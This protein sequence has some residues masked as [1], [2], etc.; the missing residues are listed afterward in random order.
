MTK[1]KPLLVGTILLALVT[2]VVSLVPGFAQDVKS[3]APE[4]LLPAD[5]L[6]YVGW[7]GTA[8]HRAAWEKT[9]AYEAVVK[10][11]LGD[12]IAKLTEFAEQQAGPGAPVRQVV[13]GLESLLGSGFYLAVGAPN[14]GDGP[15]APQATLVVPGGAA[16]IVQINA[17]TG[18]VAAAGA[19]EI[20]NE[21]VGPRAVTRMRIREMPGME[22][23]WWAEGK[24]LVIAAGMGAV[25]TALNTA[26]GKSPTIETSAVWKKYRAKADFEVALT[27]WIDLAAI[28]KIAGPIPV[29]PPVAGQPPTTVADILKSIGLD[30]IGPAAMRLGFKGK[31]VWSETTLEAPAPRTGLLAWDSKP[32]ALVDLPPLPEATDGFYAGRMDWSSI[33]AGLVRTGSELFQMLEPPNAPSFGARLKDTERHLGVDLQK[34]LFDPLGDLIVFYGDPR[35]GVFGLGTGLAISVDDAKTLRA[36]LDKL[37]GPLL[38]GAGPDV[39]V[40]G[41]KKSGRTVRYL[42]FPAFPIISP[43]WTVDDKW[44]VIGLSPQTIDAFIR[45]LDGKLDRWVPNAE[46]KAALAEMPTKYTSITYSDPREGIRTA[47]SMVPVLAS[48]V[49]MMRMQSQ[50]FPGQPIQQQPE[51]PFSAA[52]LPPAEVVTR[53][54]FPN[55]SVCTTTDGEIRWTSRTSLPAVPLLGGAGLGN[56]GTTVPVLAALLLPAVQQA[57][58]AARRAQSTNNLKQIGLALHN[59]HDV[60]NGFPAGTH[61]NEKLKP[62]KRLSWQVDILPYIDQAPVYNQIDFKKAWDDDPNAEL[63]KIQLPVYMNPSLVFAPNGKVGLTSYVG[64]AGIG[65]DGPMLP[66]DNAKAGFFG[67]DRVINIRNITDGTSSTMGVCDVSKDLGGWA[68]GGKSTIRP[69]TVKPYINGPD[70]LGGV[71]R[72][73]MNVLMVDG[74]V[75]FVSEAINADI[76]EALVTIAGGEVIGDF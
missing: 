21:K 30:K 36:T 44:L 34:E 72:G 20:E 5:A 4:K 6:L 58:E 42:E 73:G 3:P 56:A 25:D 14:S 40:Q 13:G 19:A 37:M 17:L 7:D 38:Q 68:V 1:R 12:V 67:Y 2:G 10:S 54:L 41:A 63:V 35:Q 50:Q 43:A 76:L 75:R 11:G 32:V 24:H 69:L 59:F 31:A 64:L 71:H 48:T 16:A 49:G 52:D 74:S 66:V 23:G 29:S 33:G 18:Q 26:A 57:R 45:R 15:P 70:G 61:E 53:P 51:S 27:T 9:A 65:K 28:R 22:F 60:N 47:I 55:L 62:E 39:R 46:A 8:A